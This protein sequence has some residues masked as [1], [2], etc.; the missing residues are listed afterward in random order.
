V[1]VPG[2]KGDAHEERDKDDPEPREHDP[3]VF[4]FGRLEGRHAVRHR[5]HP[6]QRRASGSE[7]AQ[8]EEN[9]EILDGG[10]TRI[11]DVRRRVP[12]EGPAYET[13]DDED[14]HERDEQIGGQGEQ[15][16]GLPQPSQVGHGDGGDKAH[17]DDHAVVVEGGHGRGQGSHASR[18]AHRHREHVVDEE[19]RARDQPRQRSQIVLGDDV[20]AAALRV[21]ENSL[22]VRAHHDRDE[23][24]DGEA[25]GNRVVESDRPRQDEDEQDLFRSVGHGGERVR[26]E[27]G[28]GGGLGKPFVAS[29]RRRQRASDKYFLERVEFH[30]GFPKALP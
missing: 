29:L 16:A 1:I 15:I 9:T 7:G 22:P 12:S 28:Q 6:S 23:G 19:G 3:R 26:G 13:V 4:R 27:D 24:G 5:L 17:P 30:S 11:G 18:H 14:G 21:G 10:D 8:D 20:R 2:E 25:D